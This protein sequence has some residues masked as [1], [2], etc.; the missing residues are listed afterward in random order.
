GTQAL[1]RLLITQARLDAEAGR[2]TAGFVSGYRGSPL[3]GVDQLLWANRPL[4]DQNRIDFLPAVNEELAATA[5]LGSQQ[6]ET[7]P[8]RLREGVFALWYGKGPGV[9]RAGDALRHGNAFGSSPHG[10]V[11]VVAGDDHGCVSSHLPHQS[12]FTLKAWSLPIVNPTGLADLLDFGLYGW[13]LSRF[14]G[15]WVGLKAISETIE[16]SATVDL[17]ALRLRFTAPDGY[18]YPADGLHC[19]PADP[20]SPAFEARLAAKLDAARAFARHN[21]IDRLILPTPGADLGLITCGKAHA[22]LLEVFRRLGLSLDQLAQAGIRLYKIGQSYPLETEGLDRFLG[23]L[24]EV[25]IVEEKGPLIEGQIRDRLYNRPASQRPAILGKTDIEGRPYIPALG[26]LRPSKL[27]PLIAAWLA[28]HRPGLDRRHLVRE[29]VAPELL[30]NE[31]DTVRRRPYYCSGCPHSVS[32]RVP[33]GSRAQPGIGCHYMA[34]W[35][36]RSTAGALQM[37]GEG[38]DW[39][40]RSRFTAEGHVFQNLGDGTYFHSGLLAIRQAV[41]AGATLTYKILFNDAVAMTGGQPVEG[42]LSVDGIA[43][44]VSAEG[45]KAVV[46]VSDDPEKHRRRAALFPAGTMFHGRKELDAVQRRLRETKG[47]T[48][49]IYDQTCAAELRRRR[50]RG[51]APDPDRRVFINSAVC[52]GCGDC[53]Q[54]SNCLSVLPVETDLGTKRRIDQSNCNKDAS[55]LDGFCP[56]LVTVTGGRPKKRS[57]DPAALVTLRDRIDR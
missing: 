9:D 2:N 25:V 8:K 26:E 46:V 31:A 12:D 44:Q 19:R 37:G 6:V 15:A 48:V 17:D 28:S 51:E 4:L 41:A 22:D 47:V 16:S 38:V 56:S 18:A 42:H 14:S 5:I 11:L 23:G 29:F 1:L 39:A 21:V 52:E 35:M 30:S 50:K 33:E 3:G 34:V 40:G 10:G 54:A 20:P 45:A 24:S 27:M 57:S 55:C 43:W 32:T 13:A 7:D 53:G 49:L 36:N